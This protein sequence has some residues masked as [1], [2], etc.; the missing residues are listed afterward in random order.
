MTADQEWGVR[1][2]ETPLGIGD[3]EVPSHL[4][5]AGGEGQEVR[6]RRRQVDEVLVDRSPAV[7]DVKTFVG[8]IRVAPDLSGR[9]RVD[10][11]EVIWRRDVD[12]AVSQDR[13]GLYRL[14]LVRLECPGQGHLVN[15]RRRDLSQTAMPPSG[16]V[17]VIRQPAVG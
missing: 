8:R 15:V 17:A 10:C 4:A 16:I 13:R 9:S 2:P 14:R 7:P 12:D 5:V 3:L 1:G 6:V 11:P